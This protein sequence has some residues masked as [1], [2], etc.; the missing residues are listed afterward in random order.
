MLGSLQDAEDLVQETLLRAWQKLDLYEGRA[1]FGTW[2]YRIATNACLDALA[3]RP[4]R[5]LP[6]GYQPASDPQEPA[7][8]PVTEPIWLEPLPDDLLDD[9]SN[10]PEARYD[11]RESISLAFLAALQ[12]LPPRQRA[13]LILCDV[14]DWRA[15]EVA[16]ALGLTVSS[17]NSAL[18]RARVSLAKHYSAHPL[19]AMAAV[20]TDEKMRALLER[21][22]Q[23]WENADL[24]G[25]M[26]LLKEEATFTMP[27]SPSWYAGRNAIRTFISQ[28]I[29]AG[30]ASARFR[31]VPTH[32][33]SQPAFAWYQREP[34][35]AR[36]LAFGIQVLTFDGEL[37][38]DITTFPNPGLFRYFGLP[39]E[40]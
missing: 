1:S 22:A 34:E 17:V 9:L 16:G 5:V 27:P 8:P 21:Y 24:D 14:L 38:A 4:H 30:E 25:L 36:Y 29:L 26:A 20:P 12:V 11:I 19:E 10:S 31:L 32:A 39:L 23:A 18:H 33:N 28:R 6:P 35:G 2:L 40:L 7:R 15:H 37:L 13:V 3:R